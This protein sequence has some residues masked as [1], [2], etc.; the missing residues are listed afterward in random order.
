MLTRIYF[1]SYYDHRRKRF[2]IKGPEARLYM[3]C[4]AAIM[5]PAA[6]F[7]YAWCSFPWVPWIAQ[8]IAI[9]V[10]PLSFIS[11]LSTILKPANL[12][13]IRLGC[14]H[15]IRRSLHLFCRLVG[16]P[17]RTLKYSV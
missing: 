7:I 9:T 4:V 16:K 2:P 14:L 10:R 1:L 15:R 12:L 8:A 17:P 6:M 11:V 3:P 13:D 5:I